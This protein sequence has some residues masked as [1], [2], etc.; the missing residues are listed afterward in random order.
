MVWSDGMV[1]G[2]CW[3]ERKP[4]LNKWNHYSHERHFYSCW[5]KMDGNSASRFNYNNVFGDRWWPMNGI[6][7][8]W[9]SI[10]LVFIS[11]GTGGTLWKEYYLMGHLLLISTISSKR[12][13]SKHFF[14]NGT[15]FRKSSTFFSW[16]CLWNSLVLH[17]KDQFS[18]LTS[19][20]VV[21]LFL[22]LKQISVR[23]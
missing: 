14:H 17:P 21:R 2:H 18:L 19:S 3:N 10:Y 23:K 5:C 12:I 16:N 15:A 13:S 6:Y 1:P 20:P 22:Q 9:Q 7:P 4:L 11:L 8:S